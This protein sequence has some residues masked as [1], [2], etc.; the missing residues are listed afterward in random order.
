MS[1]NSLLLCGPRDKGARIQQQP[2]LTDGLVMA[3]LVPWRGYIEGI[4]KGKVERDEVKNLKM[5]LESS[6]RIARESSE[7]SYI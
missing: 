7:F 2:E 1:L 4:F 5:V 3:L 6:Q